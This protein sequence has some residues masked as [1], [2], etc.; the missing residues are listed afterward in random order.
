ML[1]FG[2]FRVYGFEGFRVTGLGFRIGF[3]VGV[4]KCRHWLRVPRFKVYTLPTGHKVWY[5]KRG[6]DRRSRKLV[7]PKL[8]ALET[9]ISH[10]A[11]SSPDG[12]GMPSNLTT[13]LLNTFQI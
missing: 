11:S 13:V 5:S 9:Y 10:P 7:S 2:G 6:A 4:L 3:R 1:G 12:A 8:L